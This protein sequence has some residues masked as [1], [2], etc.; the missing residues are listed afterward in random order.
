MRTPS[1]VGHIREQ[2]G[3]L[4]QVSAELSARE[5]PRLFGR[6][7]ERN[8]V[9]HQVQQTAHQAR[10]AARLIEQVTGASEAAR[11]VDEAA[12]LLQ[13][14]A[15]PRA[16]NRA[17]QQFDA[18]LRAALPVVASAID[19]HERQLLEPLRRLTT[20]DVAASLSELLAA[21][22]STLTRA[23]WGRVRRLTLDAPAAAQLKGPVLVAGG[24]DAGW[25][26][27]GLANGSHGLGPYGDHFIGTWRAVSAAHLGTAEQRLRQ[28]AVKASKG[29]DEY[30]RAERAALQRLLPDEAWHAQVDTSAQRVLDGTAT[31][32]DVRRVHWATDADLER[33]RLSG[34]DRTRILLTRADRDILDEHARD[35]VRWVDDA[36]AALEAARVQ[37]PRDPTIAPLVDEALRLTTLN[38]LRLG[39]HTP[40]G[41]VVGYMN[42][43]DYAELGRVRSTV[44][45]VRSLADAQP[46]QAR[47]TVQS[48]AESMS[49]TW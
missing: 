6:L 29:L 36:T 4:S 14:P 12:A 5:Q 24:N 23:D 35:A 13:A 32:Q 46:S 40:T 19:D 10:E 8:K 17:V 44:A 26:L 11:M 41:A 1:G 22:P 25:Y 15:S 9:R 27:D 38:G 7:T 48:S 3:S 21:H 37:F 33:M 45:L 34:P 18:Q 49:L 47:S 31:A 42:H 2:M 16:L 20:D 39:H 30:E 28:L 43:P